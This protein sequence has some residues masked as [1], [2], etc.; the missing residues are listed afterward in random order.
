MTLAAVLR[1]TDGYVV[2]TDALTADVGH[3]FRTGPKFAEYEGAV[4]ALAGAAVAWPGDA[5]SSTLLALADGSTEWLRVAHWGVN[6][7]ADGREFAVADRLFAIGS[8]SAVAVG[9]LA[10]L[11]GGLTMVEAVPKVRKALEAACE[12]ALG[13]SAPVYCTTIALAGPETLSLGF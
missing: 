4:L 13:C 8:G 2:A 10:T 5:E 12:F 1:V 3:V 11:P 9:A 6:C 7:Y